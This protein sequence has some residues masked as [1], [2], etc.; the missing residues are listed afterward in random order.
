MFIEVTAETRM[1]IKD[2]KI[3]AYLQPKHF[4]AGQQRLGSS[5][6]IY[7]KMECSISAEHTAEIRLT[8]TFDLPTQQLPE[9]L[10]KLW[11]CIFRCP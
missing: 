3:G 8:C 10:Y 5:R 6:L 9:E 11:R 1:P 2:P 7:H 4:Y